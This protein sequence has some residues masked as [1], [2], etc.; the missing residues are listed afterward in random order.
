ML[1]VGTMMAQTDSTWLVRVKPVSDSIPVKMNMDAVYDRPFLQMG[2]IPVALGGYVEANT[3]WFSTDGVSDGLSFQ[4]P[5]LTMFMSSSIARRI[6]FFTEIEF[7]EGGREIN[8]EFAS[9]DIQFHPALTLRGGVVMNPIGAFNQNHDGPKW[10]FISRPV[11]ATQMLPATWSNVGFGMYGKFYRDNWT[12]G[13][14]I[15]LTNGFDDNII[16]NTENRT[17]LP[18]SKENHQRFEESFNGQP[19]YTGKLS[20]RRHNVGE[21]GFSYMGGVFNKFQDDGLTL[22]RKRWLNTFAVDFNTILPITNTKLLGE[23]AW[24]S[25][26]VPDTYGQQFGNRQHGGFVDVVQPILRRKLLGWDN[27]VF[28]AVFRFEYVDWNAGTFR[29]TGTNIADDFRALVPGISFRP[30]AQTVLRLNYLYE[31]QRDILGNP[32][33]RTAGWQFGMSSYF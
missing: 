22:D 8:I 12:L 32:P 29:E 31:W 2:K 18:A 7:E 30:T 13:Y 9:V 3:A 11:S 1:M 5:R 33:A 14:E 4:L 16:S 10:D 6:K 27:A 23:W 19:L 26:D 28:S 25:V 21:I 17:S 15:Y 24:V 20:L